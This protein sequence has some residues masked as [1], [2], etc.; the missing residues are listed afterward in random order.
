MF[1]RLDTKWKRDGI[2][3][4]GE[5][6]RGCQLNQLDTP[7]GIC[8]D[9]NDQTLYIC[10]SKNHRIIEWKKGALNGRIIAGGNGQGDQ[11]NQ[12]NE[13]SAIVVDHEMNTLIIA[14]TGN[15]RV[16][17]CSRRNQNMNVHV[18][19]SNIDCYSLALDKDGSLYVCD[20][21]KNEIKKWKRGDNED[22]GIVVAGGNGQGENLNQL[23][24][25]NYIFVD[26][27][28][29]VYVSDTDNYRV[30]KWIKNAREGIIVAGG[31][32]D[33]DSLNALDCPRGIFVDRLG[34][35]YVS[36]CENNRVMRW[37]EG[38][39]EGYLVVG[40]NKKDSQF[41]N[42]EGLT[43]DREG[44]LYVVDSLN[45]RIMKFELDFN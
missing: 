26:D 19:I 16:I 25:P 4:C 20:H 34:R 45:H 24:S 23:D 30:V 7:I 8:I 35:I 27:D 13:P 44:N 40:G 5:T 29:T 42:T 32:S 18:R 33:G 17:E 36:D 39:E 15:R 21:V 14:D 3:V 1:F 10:D 11:S 31:N 37:C 12:L 22:R 41:K 28:Y 38:D 43:F 2:V 6:G 9:E